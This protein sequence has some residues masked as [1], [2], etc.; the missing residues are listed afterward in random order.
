MLLER[1]KKKKVGY[2]KGRKE[3]K[4][5]KKVGLLLKRNRYTFLGKECCQLLALLG[6]VK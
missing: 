3:R 2:K 5:K 6:E 1:K 4:K